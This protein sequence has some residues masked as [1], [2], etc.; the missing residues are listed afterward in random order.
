MSADEI[1]ISVN[2]GTDREVFFTKG[3]KLVFTMAFHW[4]QKFMPSCARYMKCRDASIFIA[5]YTGTLFHFAYGANL[6]NRRINTLSGGMDSLMAYKFPSLLWN[7]VGIFNRLHEGWVT[8]D[9]LGDPDS[10]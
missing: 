2:V 8:Q 10:T 5:L 4:R 6:L 9:A 3:L 7:L 1:E